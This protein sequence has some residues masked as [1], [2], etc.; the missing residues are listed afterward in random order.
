MLESV[1]IWRDTEKKTNPKDD[2]NNIWPKLTEETLTSGKSSRSVLSKERGS[3]IQSN[4]LIQ[5]SNGPVGCME[6]IGLK[7]KS[8]LL[9]THNKQQIVS[10]FMVN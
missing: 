9:Y 7:Y 10:L 2:S 6:G 4:D 5:F 8:Q 1:W 3:A